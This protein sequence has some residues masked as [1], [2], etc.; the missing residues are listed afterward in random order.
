[1]KIKIK[2]FEEDFLEA[3]GAGVYEI[4]VNI[5]GTSKALY[6]GESVFVLVRCSIHLFELRNNPA[7]FGFTADTI[8]DDRITL[9]FKLL[10][11]EEDKKKRKEI[12]IAKIKEIETL[13]QSGINDHLKEVKA[14]TEAL[15]NFLQKYI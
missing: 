1:M 5:N 3:I 4:D 12:E 14:R 13:S 7:Y 11:Q 2:F 6:I 15:D 8:N 10:Q 9:T